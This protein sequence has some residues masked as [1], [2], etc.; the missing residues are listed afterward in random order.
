MTADGVVEESGVDL[1]VEIFA[2][3]FFDLQTLALG[4][5]PFEIVVPLLQ[6]KRNPAELV[7]DQDDLEL[8]ETLEDA[9]IDQVIEAV[10]RLEQFHVDAVGLRGHA[11]G[12]VSEAE[13]PPSA[14]AVAAQ[15][16]Q[17]DRH[18]EILRG[19]PELIV[20]R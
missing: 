7:L 19:L 6:D 20:M 11:A 15:D 9:R 1:V 8:G 2:G 10:D 3:E 17:V 4:A 16:V 14:V 12:G 5:V 13:G 18:A